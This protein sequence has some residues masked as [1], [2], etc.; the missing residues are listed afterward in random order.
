M[1]DI[2][3]PSPSEPSP[4]LLAGYV[5]GDLTPAEIDRVEAYLHE[6]P[7]RQAEIASLMLPLDLL[8]LTLPIAEP[9]D[10]LRAQILQAAAPDSLAI[11][12]ITQPPQ[13][14]RQWWKPIADGLELALIAYFGWYNYRLS[15]ELATVKQDLQIAQ[16]ASRKPALGNDRSILSLLQQP[17]NRL[18]SLKNLPGQT[19]AGSLVVVP[20]KSVAVLILQQV[21]PLPPGQVY[22][23]WAIVGEEEMSCADFL[24]DKDG[25]VLVKIP[26]DRLK[27][28][29][30]VTITIEQKDATEAEGE[31][32]IEGEI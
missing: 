32:A 3:S 30:K 11:M 9:P 18:I 23:T 14:S 16:I 8:P 26:L 10:S 5:L 4:E 17:N 13:K 20:K 28:A 24:P 1:P 15:Q 29:T 25:K 22:R 7:E 2:Y 31:I 27:K 21:Q 19:G 12:P 6:N